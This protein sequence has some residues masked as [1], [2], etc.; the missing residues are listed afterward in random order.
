MKT[1]KLVRI[2]LDKPIAELV[3]KTD[4]RVLGIWAADSAKRV[5]PI[6]EKEYPEDDH[7]R[8]AIK[9]LRRW[10]KDGVFKMKDIRKASLDSHASARISK[11]D[12]AKSAARAAGQAVATA[13]VRTHAIGAAIYAATAIRDKTGSLDKVKKERDWQYNHLI[14]LN[15]KFGK[16]GQKL[17]R[18]N[19]KRCVN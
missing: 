19:K 2:D 5:L 17:W 12:A 4:H 8:K 9:T 13:H 7:P 6:F 3:N 1:P 16:T 18:S 11:D 10:I 14:K 15:K